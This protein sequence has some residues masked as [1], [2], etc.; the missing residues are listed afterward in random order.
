[1]V[2]SGGAWHFP[3]MTACLVTVQLLGHPVQGLEKGALSMRIFHRT[4]Y[5][6]VDSISLDGFAVSNVNDSKGSTWFWLQ[7]ELAHKQEKGDTVLSIEVPERLVGEYEDPQL[8]GQKVRLPWTEA[9]KYV[10]SIRIEE[11]S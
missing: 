10:A 9:N 4:Y 8:L 3:L 5:Q 6:V 7:E 1:M 2:N 11:S